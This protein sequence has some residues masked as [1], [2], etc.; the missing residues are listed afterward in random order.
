ME[1]PRIVIVG[2][3]ATKLSTPAPA[4]EMYQGALF[5]AAVGYAESW[6]LP[7]YVISAMHGIIKPDFIVEPYDRRVPTRRDELVPWLQCR[8]WEA[9]D[10]VE[11]RGMSKMFVLLCGADY[12]AAFDS[13]EIS[14]RDFPTEE[15]LAHMGIGEQRSWLSSNRRGAE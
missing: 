6:S 7:W 2:C 10:R 15:P 13:R 9:Y 1:L 14:L 3:S 8:N 12:R 5:K 11:P 4:R